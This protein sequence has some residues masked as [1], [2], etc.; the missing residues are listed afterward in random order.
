[1][2]GVVEP[3]LTPREN[4]ALDLVFDVLGESRFNRHMD[5]YRAIAARTPKL[6]VLHA[7]INKI[8]ED[9]AIGGRRPYQICTFKRGDRYYRYE[10]I[11]VV[12]SRETLRRAWMK[13]GMRDL[14]R[15][16][17]RAKEGLQAK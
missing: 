8:L 12:L 1:M 16:A 6:D 11:P 15:Q 3:F 9:W 4:L 14:Q 5:E 13:S 7:D 2:E 10:E 17:R